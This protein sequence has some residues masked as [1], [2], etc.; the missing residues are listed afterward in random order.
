MW[1]NSKSLTLS[2]FCTR[3][4]AVLLAVGVCAAP[5]IVSW[6]FGDAP[7]IQA[8]HL[9]FRVTIYLCA[10]PG[11]ILLYC[12]NTLL[13]NIRVGSVFVLENTKMLRII[14]WSCIAAGVITFGSGFYYASF[15]IVAVACAFF[16]LIIRV[17]K[18]VFE[19]AIELKSEN[20]FTI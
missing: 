20:D 5:A 16:A 12:L 18:N 6:Y 3:L 8:L 13:K 19:Q 2:I 10:V 15:F 7:T 14:S 17:I 11:F 4:F 9:P 1:N